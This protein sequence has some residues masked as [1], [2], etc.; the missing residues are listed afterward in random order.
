MLDYLGGDT[1][2]G[3]VRWDV[4]E[5]DGA[6]A[7]GRPLAYPDAGDYGRSGSDPGAFA[8]VDVAAEGYV[9]STLWPG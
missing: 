5:D 1:G 4:V 3:S 7:D 2:D 9:R 8:N 6:G